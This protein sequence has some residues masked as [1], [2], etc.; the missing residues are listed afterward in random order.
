MVF[1]RGIAALPTSRS[2]FPDDVLTV[3][4]EEGKDDERKSLESVALTE[5][6]N[7]ETEPRLNSLR[8]LP[9]VGCP[10]PS[11]MALLKCRF[12]SVPAD[13]DP[14]AVLGR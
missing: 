11:A 10:S 2:L 14:T 3:E 6:C 7:A 13:M 9:E 1:G 4:T 8:G 5:R 12:D